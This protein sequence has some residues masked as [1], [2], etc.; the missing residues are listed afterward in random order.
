MR[1][2]TTICFLLS[3][4]GVFG[5]V[6]SKHKHTPQVFPLGS[7]PKNKENDATGTAAGVSKFPVLSRIAGVEWTGTCRYVN[8]ELVHAEKLKLVGGL[9]YDMDVMEDTSVVQL[10]LSSFLTFPNGQRRE[11]V[12]TNKDDSNDNK[13]TKT[14]R[15]DSAAEEGGPIYMLLTE[16]AP[17]TVLINE[18]EKATGNIIMTSSLSVVTVYNNGAS[19][20]ELVQVSHEVG[21][22]KSASSIDGHQ[23]WRLK[24]SKAN[25]DKTIQ[26]GEYDD[27][28][29]MAR[30]TTGR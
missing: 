9:R 23:V 2:L 25:N 30:E 3:L 27:F 26:G 5:F 19:E 15:L 11:V 6:P 1:V 10:K 16:L 14:I 8:A 18:I 24:K 17:D 21:D 12:M 4:L 13:A 22:T 29:S 7:T 28:E 20:T